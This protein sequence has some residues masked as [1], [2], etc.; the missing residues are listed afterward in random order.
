MWEAHHLTWNLD[1]YSKH[2]WI[3]VK[4]LYILRNEKKRGNEYLHV[5]KI[6][7]FSKMKKFNL[8]NNIIL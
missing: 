5:L 1:F 4:H 6:F 2:F 8:R 3:F 7:G